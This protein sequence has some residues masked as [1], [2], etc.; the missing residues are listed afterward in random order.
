MIPSSGRSAWVSVAAVL[1]LHTLLISFQANRRFDTDVFR[2]WLL[3]GLAAIEKVVDVSVR[4]VPWAWRRYLGLL[5][6]RE[7]NAQLRLEID[8]LRM[9]LEEY[10]EDVVEARRLR[11]LLGLQESSIGRGVAA[12]VVG[13]DTGEFHRTVTIDKGRSHGVTM[14]SPVIGTE[15]V[16]GRVIHAASFF[17]IVQ[18]ITDSQSG[19]GVLVRSSRRQGVVQGTG[20]PELEIGYMDEYSELRV[21]DILL[22]SG[23]DRLYPKGLP[24]GTIASVGPQR[25]LFR[26]VRIRPTADLGRLE[27]V[28]C[29]VDRPESLEHIP[30][31]N[32]PSAP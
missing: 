7:E 30:M 9:M 2:V 21:G 18:L 23:T 17:S 11:H 1:F 24:V 3:D 5:D 10:R 22:T 26:V 8:D 19:V 20:G 31:L 27:E 4:G 15:G 6:V 16:I 29:L 12:R 14:D 25:G 32:G 28:L 13:R